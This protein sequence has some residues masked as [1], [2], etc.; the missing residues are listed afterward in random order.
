[1]WSS[2]CEPYLWNEQAAHAK[3]EQ[4]V[5]PGGPVCPHCGAA[6][7]IGAVTGKGARAGL[8]FCC[9][10]R[11]QFRATMATIFAGSHVPLHKWFQAC[12]LLTVGDNRISAHRLHL[13]LGVTIR[14]AAHMLCRLERV[15]LEAGGHD[16]VGVGVGVGRDRSSWADTFGRPRG[17][18]RRGIAA[19]WG[20]P[21]AGDAGGPGATGRMGPPRAGF[22]PDP[23]A[24]PGPAP[25]R[26]FFGFLETARALAANRTG[27]DEV[28]AQLERRTAA[29]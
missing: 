6:D 29:L 25:T 2:I 9:R 19:A 26:Q 21:E 11:K 23:R 24:K 13:Q 16:D 8:K 5:W 17:R 15:R 7:R 4:I 28:P 22:A 3:L 12:F 27:F 10:C 18:L 1:M 20:A 14:T